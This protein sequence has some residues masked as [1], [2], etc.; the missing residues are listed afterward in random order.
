MLVL[1]VLRDAHGL[2]C[3]CCVVVIMPSENIARE[4]IYRQSSTS[5][6]QEPST[7]AHGRIYGY[8]SPMS[9]TIEA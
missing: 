4:R 9:P 2:H 7:E 5:T 6:L 3:C 8:S 1:A